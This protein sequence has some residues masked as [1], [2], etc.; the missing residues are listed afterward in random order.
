[1]GAS[2][3]P[4]GDALLPQRSAFI[5][6]DEAHETSRLSK[7]KRSAEFWRRATRIYAGF[8]VRRMTAS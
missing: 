7:W 1:M 8:K 6:G 2:G 4:G 5:S 3:A